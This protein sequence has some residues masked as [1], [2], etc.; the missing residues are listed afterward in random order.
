MGRHFE[1]ILAPVRIERLGGVDAE[2]AEGVDRDEYVGDI[3]LESV[4]DAA[5]RHS[6]RSPGC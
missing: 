1:T 5:R 4:M 2:I 3:C 6:H